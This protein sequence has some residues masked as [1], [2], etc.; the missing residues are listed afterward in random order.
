[1]CKFSFQNPDHLKIPNFRPKTIFD[2]SH[3]SPELFSD[4][5]VQPFLMQPSKE[6]QTQLHF[7]WNT[8]SSSLAKNLDKSWLLSWI[9]N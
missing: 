4:A 2:Q 6:N 9:R 5:F 3:F 7:L 8:G 1:M